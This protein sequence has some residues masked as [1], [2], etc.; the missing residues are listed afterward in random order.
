MNTVV[1]VEQMIEEWKKAGIANTLFLVEL[2]KA[3]MGWPYVFGEDGQ[4]CTPSNR[5]AAYN[6]HGKDNPTIKSKC[7]N[8]EGTKTCTG[9]KWH[10]H[11][12]CTLF[13]D[14]QGF[15]KWLF[16]HIGITLKGVGCT[17]MW[18]DDSN[19][20][21]KGPIAEM[22]RD[23]VCLVFR[24]DGNKMQHIL[25][26]DGA[27]YYLHC[28]GEVKKTAMG[29]YNATHY[30]IPKGLYDQPIPP[31]P[32]PEPPKGKAIVTGRNVA[33]R[34]GPGTNTS[35][36][37][38]IATGMVVDLV[39]ISGWTYVRYVNQRGFMM[40]EYIEIHENDIKVTGKNVALRAGAGTDTRVLTRIKTGETVPREKIPDGWAHVEYKGKKG[41]M[42]K[43]YIKE[44]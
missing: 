33:L 24:K 5:R 37:V 1:Q 29:S 41:F 23:K 9:C 4:K 35:V 10:P 17:S 38:R 16:R 3:C 25:L 14:C 43:E 15:M 39:D 28:S 7:M 11:G 22:P 40:N 19:W 42:M 18:N 12:G 27:G 31:E 6:R 32:T 21:Q 2:A 30:G 34:Q 20:L 26:Y 36:I 13:F 8:F 44:G